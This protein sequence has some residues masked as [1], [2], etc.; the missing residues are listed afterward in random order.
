MI[1]IVA[2][3]SEYPGVATVAG[4]AERL[5]E[6]RLASCANNHAPLPASVAATRERSRIESSP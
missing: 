6:R 4:I 1:R 2:V 5:P 3:E